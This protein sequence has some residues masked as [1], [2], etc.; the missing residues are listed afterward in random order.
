MPSPQNPTEL[1]S[2]VAFGI[3]Y[4]LVL[5]CLAAA[6]HFVPNQGLYV[7]AGI[8]GL[9]DMDA[10]TLSTARMSLSDPEIFHSGWRLIVLAALAN[11]VSKAVLA[12]IIGGRQLL[13][14]IAALFLPSL[15]G[16]ALLLWLWRGG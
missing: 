6:R 1:R 10:I 4:S 11:L 12:G 3:M 15:V 8:S 14:T 5:F 13:R 9:T 7:V 2:A 16:G